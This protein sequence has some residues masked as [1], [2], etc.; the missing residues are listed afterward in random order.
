MT[1]EDDHELIGGAIYAMGPSVLCLI[2]VHQ[3]SPPVFSRKGQDSIRDATVTFAL[4][5]TL[6]VLA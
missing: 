1:A 5:C 2:L 4:Y 6:Q 3:R